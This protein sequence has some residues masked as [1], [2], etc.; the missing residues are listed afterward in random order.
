[1]QT[2][3]TLLPVYNKLYDLNLS[4]AEVE[5]ITTKVDNLESSK[6]SYS[7]VA[8]ET[9]VRLYPRDKY[10]RRAKNVEL[11]PYDKD[12]DE[13]K[14][15]DWFINNTLLKHVPCYNM[16][17]FD[18]E[19]IFKDIDVLKLDDED[20]EM[21]PAAASLLK[22]TLKKGDKI[23][24]AIVSSVEDLK[25]RL[26]ERFLNSFVAERYITNKTR[27]LEV[28]PAQLIGWAFDIKLTPGN[29]PGRLRNDSDFV[30]QFTEIGEDDNVRIGIAMRKT[31]SFYRQHV[32][33]A[34][35]V[36]DCD[37][38]V[39]DYMDKDRQFYASE[40]DVPTGDWRSNEAIHTLPKLFLLN[41]DVHPP[42]AEEVFVDIANRNTDKEALLVDSLMLETVIKRFQRRDMVAQNKEQQKE[43]LKTKFKKKLDKI[44]QDDDDETS[45]SLN[46]IKMSKHTIEYGGQTLSCDQIKVYDLVERYAGYRGLDDLNFD[47]L[48]DDFFHRLTNDV[49]R[50]YSSKEWTGKIGEIDYNL[51]LKCSRNKAGANMRL[52]YMNG[53]K[54]KKDEV[55]DIARRA[56]C[57]ED[58]E[59][60]DGFCHQVSK[61]SLKLHKYLN[62]GIHLKVTDDY[63]NQRINF[64]I[65]LIRK[66]GK[67]FI[68]LDDKEYGVADSNRLIRLQEASHMHDAINT[69]L[70]PKVVRIDGPDDIAHIIRKGEELHEQDKDKNKKLIEKVE[71]LFGIE[72]TSI[73]TNGTRQRGYVIDGKMSKYFLDIGRTDKETVFDRLRVF[74]YPDMA[75]VC[76]IDKTVQQTGPSNLINR[77][78]ALHNDSLVARD[79]NTL[80]Q[81]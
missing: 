48:S 69:L 14:N 62:E 33:T 34:I 75:Y 32:D 15:G 60:F 39:Y 30:Y 56:L 37:N 27:G 16:E 1:M 18:Q 63:R 43:V 21:F 2:D 23:E 6:Y 65:P 22:D 24:T 44:N 81:N 72:V 74:S 55:G 19:F 46:G 40:D 78:F 51:E 53:Y 3:V 13:V 7:F 26:R 76:M 68:V 35:M 12:E 73:T 47:T 36:A 28:N 9:L 57:Y 50:S 61:C 25:E 38:A 58:Q 52:V 11:I 67:N 59:V 77:I 41:E 17:D 71:N 80:N 66:S 5:K 70:N 4:E 49:E 29:S 10:W 54:I 20:K 45:I 31:S 64:K 8:N 79:V 42:E